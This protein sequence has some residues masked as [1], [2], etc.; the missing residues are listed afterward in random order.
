MI[1]SSFVIATEPFVPRSTV[2]DIGTWE[3]EGTLETAW[4]MAHGRGGDGDG[5]GEGERAWERKIMHGRWGMAQMESVWEMAHMRGG[6]GEG[7]HKGVGV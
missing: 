1:V 6:V 2:G 3:T 7:V 5:T 4:E